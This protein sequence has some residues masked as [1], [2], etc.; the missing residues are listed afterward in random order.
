M[1]TPPTVRIPRRDAAE[2]RVALLAAARRV[3][4]RD[5]NASLETIAAEAGLSRRAVYGHFDGR[6]ELLLELVAT[7]IA[8]V[9][10][11]LEGVSHP[12][13][14]VH[15]ALIASRLWREVSSV[16][17]MA[18]VAVRGPLA[19]QTIGGLGPIRTN[20]SA[21]IAAGQADKS[22]RTDVSI[23][24]LA[25]LVEDIA[26]AVLSESNE[27]PLPSAEGHHL[28]MTM[29]LGVVGLSS[30]AAIAL[31]SSRP[32]LAYAEPAHPESE[33]NEFE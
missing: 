23:D 11:A 32:E 5:P 6:D 30:S 17:A 7:G 8:R 22:M 3:L 24:R 2:N 9:A 13:P 1:S 25:R 18:V 16:R 12:V 20:V 19:P 27:H 14:L 28:V 21:A 10:A 31:I 29:T 4:N 33:R 15:L 26:L